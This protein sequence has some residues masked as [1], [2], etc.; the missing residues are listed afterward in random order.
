VKYAAKVSVDAGALFPRVR[1]FMGELNDTMKSFGVDQLVMARCEI[2]N[3]TINSDEAL[4]HEK[5]E[6][7]RAKAEALANSTQPEFKWMFSRLYPVE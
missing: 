6:E 5:L 2:G 4:P 1:D 7:V 3:F